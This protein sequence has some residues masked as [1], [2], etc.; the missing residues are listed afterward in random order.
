MQF[1]LPHVQ[2]ALDV[3]RRLKGST[4]VRA[5]LEGALGWLSDGVALVQADGTIVYA[6]E[7][8]QEIARRS[9]GI[10]IKKNVL[11]FIAQPARA[12]LDAA[13]GD[14]CR[15]KSGELS[16]VAPA[17][18]A[19]PRSSG[20][21]SYLVSVRALPDSHARSR[22]RAGAVAMV[23]VHDPRGQAAATIKT[24]CD[25]F[26]FTDAEAHLAQALLAGT[27]LGDYAQ[28]RA[29]SLNTIYTHL[30]RIKEK[31][32]CGRMTQ[33]IRKLNELQLSLREH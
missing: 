2:R 31:T 9:D 26:G 5:S 18:F 3:A 23:F 21:S 24:L 27:P 22:P 32:G 33:L 13:I 12:S 7:S 10:R 16:S 19:A 6:N 15:T 28:M 17:N 25:V 30:R 4:D 29:V 14:I 11:D 8:M 20:A 1:L